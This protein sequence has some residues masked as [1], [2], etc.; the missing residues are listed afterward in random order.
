MEDYWTGGAKENGASE[1]APVAEPE[2]DVEMA[3]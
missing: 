2:G 3:E 1:T